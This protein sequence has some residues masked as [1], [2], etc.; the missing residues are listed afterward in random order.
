[1]IK[2]IVVIDRRFYPSVQNFAAKADALAA[3]N[4]ALT[5]HDPDGK[6]EGRVYWAEVVGDEPIRTHY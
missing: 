5:E 6:H 2:W 4:E 1:M 3:F